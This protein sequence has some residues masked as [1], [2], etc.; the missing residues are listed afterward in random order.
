ME[1]M[2]YRGDPARIVIGA[3]RPLSR[4]NFT[5]GH[6]LG[7]HIFG[8]GSTKWGRDQLIAEMRE[9]RAFGRRPNLTSM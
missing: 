7:H 1:G 5:C 9:L 8:H 6:E 3:R 4:R 2:Y